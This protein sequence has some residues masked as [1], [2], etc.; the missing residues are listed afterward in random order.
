MEAFVETETGYHVLQYGILL[1]DWPEK[2]RKY[3]E[4]PDTLNYYV[5]VREHMFDAW[6]K[7]LTAEGIPRERI[8]RLEPGR[9]MKFG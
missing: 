3:R 7:H 6:L 2:G 4:E 5:I 1:S 9:T 8:F